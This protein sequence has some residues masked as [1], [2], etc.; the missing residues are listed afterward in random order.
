M[1]ITLSTQIY[2][3]VQAKKMPLH[4]MSLGPKGT[5]LTCV[6]VKGDIVEAWMW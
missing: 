1:K 5:F 2:C 6:A 4:K 3:R